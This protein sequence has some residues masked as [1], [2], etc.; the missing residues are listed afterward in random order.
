MRLNKAVAASGFCARRKADELIFAGRV[1]VDGKSETNPARRVS[2]GAVISVDGKPLCRKQ[3]F[4]Y[5]LLHKPVRTVCTLSDPQGRP[6]VMDCLPESL[7]G[8]GL[9]PVGRLD[10]FSDGVLLLTNDGELANL[11]THPRHHVDKV[12]EVLVRGPVTDH[13]L[14][15]MRG[16]MRL[17]D[18]TPLLPVEARRIEEKAGRDT[19]LRLTLRQGVN[20][21]IRRMCAD[22]GLTILRLR[23]VAQGGLR[24]GALRA[25]ETRFLAPEEVQ[26]LRSGAGLTEAP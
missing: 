2:A 23:R 13:Q 16:G 26:A 25:G 9:F 5:L 14:E 20:R 12:Y 4:A 15:V 21:Q 7:R 22:L 24:L 3:K 11:L 10:Y 17:S 1:A 18:G 8:M 19:L 6:T